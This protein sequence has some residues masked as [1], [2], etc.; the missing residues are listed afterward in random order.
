MA[1]RQD[2]FPGSSWGQYI[3]ESHWFYDQGHEEFATISIEKCDSDIPFEDL[4]APEI[5]AGK[6]TWLLGTLKRLYELQAPGHGGRNMLRLY[7]IVTMSH[8]AP[9]RS[10][11]ELRFILNPLFDF[12]KEG[13]PTACKAE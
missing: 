4:L 10:D 9:G 6:K 5:P 2:D 8:T 12:D 7:R 11:H 3:L 13:L 1:T